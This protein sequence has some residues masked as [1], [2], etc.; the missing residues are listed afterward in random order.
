MKKIL[1]DQNFDGP[2]LRGLLSRIPDL[3]LVRTEDIGLKGFAD[4]DILAWAAE[5]DRLIL[6]HDAKTFSR[7][8]FKRMAQGKKFSGL[9]LVPHNLSTR[10]AIEELMIVILCSTEDELQNAFMRLPM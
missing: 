3:D 2:T 8:A 9:I 1:T 6:T 7:F 4:P 10:R 5:E